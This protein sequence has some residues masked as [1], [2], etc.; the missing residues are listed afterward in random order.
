MEIINKIKL[1]L[2]NQFSFKG[3]WILYFIFIPFSALYVI[4]KNLH[5]L[6]PF[7]KEMIFNQIW[8]NNIVDNKIVSFASDK[9]YHK[10]IE[11]LIR[12]QYVDLLPKS[13]FKFKSKFLDKVVLKKFPA[14]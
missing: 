8:Y 4:S 9:V 7:C 12:N 11:W 13:K 10:G 6:N 14:I 2:N 3:L 5:C 1:L